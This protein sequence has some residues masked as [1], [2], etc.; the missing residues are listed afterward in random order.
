MGRQGRVF[1][2]AAAVLLW[3]GPTPFARA[4]PFIMGETVAVQVPERFHVQVS[5]LT[6]EA[7][8]CAFPTAISRDGEPLDVELLGPTSVT[9]NGG[10]GLGG[11]LA[12]QV[13]DCD[14]TVGQHLYEFEVPPG[15]EMC[16]DGRASVIVTDPPPPQPDPYVAPDPADYEDHP[17]DM[18]APP[19]PKGADCV[20]FCEGLTNPETQPETPP[21]DHQ[22][23]IVERV[24]DTI[25][26]PPPDAITPPPPDAITPPPTDV[27]TPNDGLG[28]DSLQPPP[29][30]S[31]T[32]S[33]FPDVVFP[34]PDGVAYEGTLWGD[35][36]VPAPDTA[37]VSD[38]GNEIDYWCDCG[39]ST[40]TSGGGI[41]DP[42]PAV[43]PESDGCSS[44][45]APGGSALFALAILGLA[46][47]R[48][49]TR[50]PAAR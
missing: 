7:D 30:P 48:R 47:A 10:S 26:P 35:E 17:W 16:S 25:S 3:L 19:W 42:P 23:E 33:P 22:V 8:W 6:L 43:V 21:E 12:L 31:D 11:Y 38:N 20:A 4:N 50:R 14:V 9:I 1:F 41:A 37:L 45:G 32:H 24:G 40:D 39:S 44:A 34:R 36:P 49:R 5:F 18:P 27:V 46:L 15:G 28:G 13:C 29:P 2:G